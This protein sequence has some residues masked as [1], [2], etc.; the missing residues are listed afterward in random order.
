VPDVI[1]VAKARA[2]L[3]GVKD[4]LVATAGRGATAKRALRVFGEGYRIYAVGNPPS[5][6]E[7]GLCLHPG[8]SEAKCRELEDLGINVAL[9]ACSMGQGEDWYAGDKVY[10]FR[11]YRLPAD[12]K[13]DA[14]IDRLG[15]AR[16]DVIRGIVL[17]VFDWFGE[18][19]RVCLEIAFMAADA[20]AVPP[21]TRV[22]AIATPVDLTVPHACVV[23][24]LA[25]SEDL[26]SWRFGIVDVAR[27]PQYTP[28]VVA[29]LKA[30][31]HFYRDLVGLQVLERDEES[32]YAEFKLGGG[33]LA[34]AET[35]A[36]PIV[37]GKTS[38]ALT[39]ESRGRQNLLFAVDDVKGVR[40]RVSDAGVTVERGDQPWITT[41]Q[42]PD[43]NQVCIMPR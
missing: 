21:N 27:V 6:Q 31:F 37:A 33:K 5:S 36:L 7:R 16:P 35:K 1:Q 4:V 32:H 17:R 29:D 41:F 15:E 38:L 39:P 42:D 8:I 13:L 9:H 20:G 24:N 43:G 19:G 10:G 25:K 40:E 18:G 3:Y 2:D 23:V 30:A 12:V 11:D 28:L 34:L 22:I 14:V 26:F